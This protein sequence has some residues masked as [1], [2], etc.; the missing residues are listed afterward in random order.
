[1]KYY[2][3]ENN[4]VDKLS[5]DVSVWGGVMGLYFYPRNFETNSVL[6]NLLF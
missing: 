3:G 6:D 5:F 2:D 4:V 1:M